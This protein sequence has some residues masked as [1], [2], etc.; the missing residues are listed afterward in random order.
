LSRRH[1]LEE[2]GKWYQASKRAEEA[3]AKLQTGAWIVHLL[4][5]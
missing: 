2:A 1:A 4:V 3:Q 5:A